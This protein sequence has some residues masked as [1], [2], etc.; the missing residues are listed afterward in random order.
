M[1]NW[2]SVAASRLHARNLVCSDAV[3]ERGSLFPFF[4]RAGAVE[5]VLIVDA[6]SSDLR[7]FRL[8]ETQLSI[9]FRGP[10]R[11]DGSLQCLDEQVLEQLAPRWHFDPWWLLRDAR[12]EDQAAVPILV[13]TNCADCFEQ[14]PNDLLFSGRLTRVRKVSFLVTK[15]ECTLQRFRREMLP[16]RTLDPTTFRAP[17]AEDW[18]LDPVW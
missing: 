16:I 13:R 15:P 2:F 10:I 6:G 3:I 7:T 18:V 14:S 9:P 11:L 1:T 12:F 5:H 8:D 4:D 17:R